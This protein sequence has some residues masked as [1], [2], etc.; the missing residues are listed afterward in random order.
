MEIEN[1]TTRHSHFSVNGLLPCL[2]Q[3]YLRLVW[4]GWEFGPERRME[5]VQPEGS[6]SPGKDWASVGPAVLSAEGK[7]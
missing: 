4:K 5:T 3:G 6:G 1:L 7:K 2:L